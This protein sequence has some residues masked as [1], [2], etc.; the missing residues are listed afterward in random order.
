MMI[1]IVV[2]LIVSNIGG[3]HNIDAVDVDYLTPFARNYVLR[4]RKN[5]E[6]LKMNYIPKEVSDCDKVQFSRI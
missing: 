5:I 3:W 4:R 6:P 2:G 1:T